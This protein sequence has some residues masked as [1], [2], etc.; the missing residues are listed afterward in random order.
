MNIYT[1]NQVITVK[2]VHPCGGNQ[3]V[4]LRTGADIRIKCLKC[5]RE[6]MIDKVKLDKMVKK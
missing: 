1:I 5:G 4:V 2:K 3:F 6:V